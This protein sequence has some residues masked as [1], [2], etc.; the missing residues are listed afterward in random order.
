MN[1]DFEN[2][3][4]LQHIKYQFNYFL[5][6]NIK[7]LFV[8]SFLA[9]SILLSFLHLHLIPSFPQH[10]SLAGLPVSRHV[11][12]SLVVDFPGPRRAE[13]YHRYGLRCGWQIFKESLSSLRLCSYLYWRSV[14]SWFGG[15][16][17]RLL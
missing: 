17:Y 5:F 2:A 1:L 4:Y 14:N 11:W 16:S 7:M 12:F 13:S 3:Y 9:A 6:Q 8:H 10:S 15:I